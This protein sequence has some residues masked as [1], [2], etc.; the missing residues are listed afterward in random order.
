[1][2]SRARQEVC[3]R[4]RH[5][6]AAPLAAPLS[7]DPFVA[8]LRPLLQSWPTGCQIAGADDAEPD[9]ALPVPRLLGPCGARVEEG[10]ST[11]AEA[12]SG[13]PANPVATIELFVLACGVCVAE[14]ATALADPSVVMVALVLGL[15]FHAGPEK[16]HSGMR[17]VPARPVSEGP[18]PKRELRLA[19]LGFGREVAPQLPWRRLRPG[20]CWE[21]GPRPVSSGSE[22]PAPRR[23]GAGGEY[24]KIQ[25]LKGRSWPEF[26]GDPPR[27]SVPLFRPGLSLLQPRPLSGRASQTRHVILTYVSRGHLVVRIFSEFWFRR[28]RRFSDE[29][30]A[31]VSTTVRPWHSGRSNKCIC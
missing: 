8:I 20:A 27:A 14:L 28:A 31:Y 18:R 9:S 21:P 25:D 26:W 1:M 23:I 29:S 13:G 10:T 12:W 3:Q 2:S 11:A 4:R 5:R 30:T 15:T 17:C 16:E 6:R 22:E 7:I 24:V 19:E